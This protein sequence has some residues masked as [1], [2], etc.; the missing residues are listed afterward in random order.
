VDP[1]VFDYQQALDTFLGDRELLLSLLE[2]FV[3]QVEQ[4]VAKLEA[5][6]QMDNMD[7]VAATAH[8]IKGSSRNLSMEELGNAAEIIES[9]GKQ[10]DRKAAEEALPGIREAFM[11]VRENLGPFL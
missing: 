7:E 1:A 3:E 11:R 10:G 5:P 6:G 8:S 4:Q 9:A 2:P